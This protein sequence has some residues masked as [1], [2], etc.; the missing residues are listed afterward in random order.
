MLMARKPRAKPS[1]KSKA[2]PRARTRPGTDPIVEA[3]MRLLQTRD[4]AKVGLREI[5]REA[6][7]S[8]STLRDS[9]EGK[10]A[11]LAAFT[12]Q[13][14]RAVLDGGPAEGETPRDR[15]FEIMMRRFDALDPYKEAVRKVARAARSDLCLA[16]ALHRNSARSQKWMVAAAGADKSGLVGAAM[17]EALVLLQSETLR[18]WLDDDDPGMAKTMAALDRGLARG[19]RAMNLLDSICDRLRAFASRDRATRGG[20][21]AN[22]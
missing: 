20:A 4:F 22:A 1:P 21:A 9:H 11:I 2:P 10:H 12:R 13:I 7:V 17:I 8:L 14:D 16:R 6:G 5:A 15:L 3:L 19:A 18:A